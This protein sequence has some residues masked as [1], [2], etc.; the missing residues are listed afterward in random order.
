MVRRPI[1][2]YVITLFFLWMYHDNVFSY[3]F[4]LCVCMLLTV[5]YVVMCMRIAL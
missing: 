5:V 4:L 3:F 1:I 2:F